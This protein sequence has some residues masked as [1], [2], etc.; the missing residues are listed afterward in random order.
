MS[1]NNI[2]LLLGNPLKFWGVCSHWILQYPVITRSIY[3]NVDIQYHLKTDWQRPKSRLCFQRRQHLSTSNWHNS[4]ENFQYFANP[5]WQC[6]G[7]NPK[8]KKMGC[9]MIPQRFS[10][11]GNY[12]VAMKYE[13]LYFTLVLL[14]QLYR[15]LSVVM[16]QG[17]WCRWLRKS[18]H[19]TAN[20]QIHQIHPWTVPAAWSRITGSC[21]NLSTCP[22][23]TP[24]T[25][26]R[27]TPALDH[28]SSGP[29]H[30]L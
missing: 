22:G 6:W 24:I 29:L 20:L 18:T 16:R 17:M 19:C 3:L 12:L 28:S 25:V 11:T 23:T 21:F 27:V 4:L 15:S 5:S 2:S 10:L 1:W 9:P 7:E 26:V 14:C 8:R 30:N 13:R